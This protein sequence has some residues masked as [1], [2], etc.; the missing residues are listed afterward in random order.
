MTVYIKIKYLR[1]VIIKFKEETK[2][3]G[4]IIVNPLSSIRGFYCMILWVNNYFYSIFL[5]KNILK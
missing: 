5:F 2:A 1:Y 4:R 3:S